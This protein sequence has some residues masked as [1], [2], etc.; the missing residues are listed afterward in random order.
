MFCKTKRLWAMSFDSTLVYCFF[1]LNQG[2]Q[3]VQWR[4]QHI[5]SGRFVFCEANMHS[6]MLK[7]VKTETKKVFLDSNLCVSWI[8]D[9][10]W[11]KEV[12]ST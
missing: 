6:V 7:I 3:V 12:I 4:H 2:C 8:K 1:V 10:K 5:N 9:A 11:Y